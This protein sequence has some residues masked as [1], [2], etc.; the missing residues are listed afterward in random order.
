MDC[1]PKQKIEDF[2][3]PWCSPES[4]ALAETTDTSRQF[5]DSER[6][7]VAV[8]DHVV[9][10]NPDRGSPLLLAYASLNLSTR[11]RKALAKCSGPW[12]QPRCLDR[13][14]GMLTNSH[15]YLLEETSPQASSL[16]SVQDSQLISA[17]EIMGRDWSMIS[18]TFFPS[19]SKQDLN[20]RSVNPSL[21]CDAYPTR[22]TIPKLRTHST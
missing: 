8:S 5:S 22:L 14:R 3:K 11:M 2:G 18:R 4:G 9:T 13:V 1:G 15:W 6:R 20:N 19:R 17:V 21:D 12:Y 16:T 7:W 10:R